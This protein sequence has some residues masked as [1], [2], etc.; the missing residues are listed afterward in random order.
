VAFKECKG[1]S[2]NVLLENQ[3]VC[4]CVW[5]QTLCY[6]YKPSGQQDERLKEDPNHTKNIKTIYS[7]F[8]LSYGI[9]NTITKQAEKHQSDGYRSVH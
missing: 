7:Y 6:L 3:R 2:L 1:P 9:Q 5:G 8:F 4:V